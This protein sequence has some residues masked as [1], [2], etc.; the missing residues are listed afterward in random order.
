M[1]VPAD[2]CIEQG[3]RFSGY[4]IIPDNFLDILSTDSHQIHDDQKIHQLRWEWS[5]HCNMVSSRVHVYGENQCLHLWK[6]L[7]NMQFYKY[8]FIK[9]FL[10]YI[11]VK[12][13]YIH[14]V[15]LESDEILRRPEEQSLNTMCLY[16]GGFIQVLWIHC[17][18]VLWWRP[19]S[20]CSSYALPFWSL[21]T[22]DFE[23]S[24]IFTVTISEG[25][26]ISQSQ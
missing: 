19:I 7:R 16:S 15:Q 18:N 5:K 2:S 11:Y 8:M 17:N 3:A 24:D 14:D 20:S 22:W 12:C 25:L 4:L 6:C 9:K 21:I 23:A 10:I 26:Y 1:N 13:M